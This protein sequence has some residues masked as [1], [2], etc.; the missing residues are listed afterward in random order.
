M[1]HQQEEDNSKN[2]KK[3]FWR[4]TLLSTSTPATASSS[5][6]PFGN[7]RTEI[8]ILSSAFFL[9]QILQEIFYESIV[10]SF[11]DAPDGTPILYTASQFT[12]IVVIAYLVSMFQDP[13]AKH[14]N[15]SN[16]Q[17]LSQKAS[18]VEQE[19][20]GNGS[21]EHS[22]AH[23]T[24]D[25]SHHHHSRADSENG[26]SKSVSTTIVT[27]PN[28]NGMVSFIKNWVPIVAL[29]GL[30][31][32]ASGLP[33]IAARL[34]EYPVKVVFK[35][36]KLIPTMFVSVLFGNHSKFSTVD[37]ISAA[38][39]CAGAAG[40][41]WNSGK[42]NN[43]NSPDS[44]DSVGKE[45]T[46]VRIESDNDNDDL[47]NESKTAAFIGVTLLIIS[48]FADAF[49]SNT[50][51]YLMRKGMSAHDLMIQI[52]TIGATVLFLALVATGEL[53][54]LIDY[55]LSHISLVYYIA[56]GAS[57]TGVGIFS[58]M[59]LIRDAGS[60]IAVTVATLRKVFTVMISF[61]LFPKSFTI[62][63]LFSSMAVFIG[64]GLQAMYNGK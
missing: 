52:N 59:L 14:K 37:Y 26:Q 29:A 60:V 36:S 44:L 48:V 13:H 23:D 24:G 10:S 18:D 22:H 42:V 45:K 2:K 21:K 28:G 40:F 50:Q 33:N 32:I 7:V 20:D 49:L 8:F 17:K 6:N 15:P 54:A 47:E 43:S 64:L 55:C 35:S 46:D 58:Y 41:A 51:Q 61:L 57:C 25:E 62:R 56:L 16:N 5:W 39:L 12:S 19:P 53:A 4:M 63:H 30:M 27:P 11:P 9:S 38:L 31:F 34:V 3:P 1:K